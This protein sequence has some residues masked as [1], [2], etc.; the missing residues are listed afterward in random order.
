MSAAWDEAE[1]T[2][3]MIRPDRK[4]RKASQSKL[5]KVLS[6]ITVLLVG[7]AAAGLLYKKKH[8]QPIQPK[9]SGKDL[10][11]LN[12]ALQK[13]KEGELVYVVGTLTNH[14]AVQYFNLRVEFDVFD[15]DAQKVESTTD[16]VNNLGPASA[17]NF[18]AIVLGTNAAD[19]KLVKTMGEADTSAKSKKDE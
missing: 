5:G 3:E 6:V 4:A 8:G 7:A 2:G 17:W 19:V 15:K 12:F 1:A 16:I 10:E 9:R 14:A 18:K 11:V 13:A